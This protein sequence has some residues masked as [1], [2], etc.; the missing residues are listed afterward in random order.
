[1]FVDNPITTQKINNVFNTGAYAIVGGQLVTGR[2][3]V[4]QMSIYAMRNNN[5]YQWSTTSPTGLNPAS[6]KRPTGNGQSGYS[7]SH[8]RYYNHYASYPTITID[9]TE[10]V[11]DTNINVWAYDNYGNNYINNRWYF[12]AGTFNLA[13]DAGVTIRE[14]DRI[15]VYWSHLGGW[16]DPNTFTTK[17]VYSYSSGYIYNGDGPTGTT[18]SFTFYPSS[19][20]SFIIIAAN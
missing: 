17:R 18:V 16:G 20:E 14:N 4:A 15:D 1:M 9:E 12:F 11:A 3:L 6:G 19:G 10:N 8:W 7:W 2:S 5:T 13:T